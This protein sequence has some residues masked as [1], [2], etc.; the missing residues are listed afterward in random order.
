MLVR[1][2]SGTE[3]QI[4]EIFHVILRTSEE[5][6]RF[7]GLYLC[8]SLLVLLVDDCSKPTGLN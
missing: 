4:E 8:R 1:F 6:K 3:G 7:Q 5:V 2:R